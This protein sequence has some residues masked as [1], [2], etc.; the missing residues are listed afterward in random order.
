MWYVYFSKETF[1]STVLMADSEILSPRDA[2]RYIAEHSIDVKV[3][4]QGV[5]KTAKKAC[6]MCF[7]FSFFFV[8]IV[9]IIS[10]CYFYIFNFLGFSF[11]I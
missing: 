9:C 10:D 7:Q 3:S 6:I 8:F 5:K 4:Q 11:K 2:G 1:I